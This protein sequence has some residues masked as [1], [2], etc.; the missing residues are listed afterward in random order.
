MII[1]PTA[2]TDVRP[3]LAM[4]CNTLTPYTVHLHRLLAHEIP[5]MRLL[6]VV[7]HG[8]A[9]FR[10]RQEAPPEIHVT[11]FAKNGEPAHGGMLG[12]PWT[13]WAKG[14]DLIRF[15]DGQSVGATILTGYGYPSHL[16][17]IR[18]LAGRRSPF[19]LRND[20]NIHIAGLRHPVRRMVKRMFFHW[21]TRRASGA[22]P[23]GEY[24][25]EYFAKYGF[26]AD[27][28]YRVPYTPDYEWFAQRDED[29]V[30]AFLQRFRLDPSRRRLLYSG[31]LNPVKRIDL[32]LDAFAGLASDRREWDVVIVGAG[33][34]ETSLRE[35][36]PELLRSRVTW[37]GFLEADALR[38]A[39]HACDALVLPSV[40]EAWAVVVQ[41]A[42]AA[43]RP[44][45]A[46]H[47]V[48]AARDLVKDGGS[49]RIFRS[50]DLQD[51]TSALLDVTDPVRLPAYQCAARMDLADWRRKVDVVREVRRALRDVGVLEAE[52]P[53]C[54]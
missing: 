2:P 41:E 29:E 9:E 17:L 46:S 50:G 47:V 51:L 28:M 39:Y 52:V 40:Q 32:L 18:H 4:V 23:M 13:D 12:A 24:G 31:R 37:T 34:M 26:S 42:M 6:S 35:R 22:M 3:A 1:A 30:A 49:G 33:P 14:A 45:I 15:F 25:I 11:H 10:W 19:F 7:T 38:A 21:A 48:G 36:V 43:G 44:V 16:R 27:R 8:S 5:E 20:A 54:A 53:A